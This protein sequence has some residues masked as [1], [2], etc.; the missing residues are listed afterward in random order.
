M[1]ADTI[2]LVFPQWQ[3]AD[4]ARWVPEV[5]QADVAARGYA[6]G[7]ELL[8][9]LAP[10]TG[11]ETLTVPVSLAPGERR[12]EGGVLDRPALIAQTRAALAMLDARAPA[13]VATLGGDC[14]VSVAP[15]SWLAA[16]HP[17]DVALLWVDAH[18]DIT[19]P[20]DPYAGWHAMALAALLGH[21]D[22]ALQALLPA[23]LAP[24]DVLLVG[25]RDWER[26]SIR[27]RQQAFGLRHLP[28]GAVAEDDAPLLDWLRARAPKHVL[29]HLD[30]DVLDPAE[31]IA[32]AGHAPDGLRLAQV[33]RLI[34]AV[35]RAHDVIGLTVAEP[36]PRVALRLRALLAALPLLR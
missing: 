13:R 3:G 33:A 34:D 12:A 23:R 6:L 30:L 20:G 17:G 32:A 25:L 10:R 9:L 35:A 15:F 16:R 2:R 19:L 28:P 31:L 11:Q 21:G 27:A 7:A 26:D 29:I 22:P 24:E 14:S 5:P 4:I 18:P 1:P 36:M 8:A